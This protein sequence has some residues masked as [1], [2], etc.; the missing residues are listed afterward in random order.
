MEEWNTTN[1]AKSLRGALL[2][3]DAP[4]TM[5]TDRALSFK[6]SST[7]P[8]AYGFLTHALQAREFFDRQPL[9]AGRIVEA[10]PVVSPAVKEEEEATRVDGFHVPAAWGST[11]PRAIAG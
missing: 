6:L 1:Y 8:A 11:A 7:E 5:F 10:H 2:T 9:V 3:L 4:V